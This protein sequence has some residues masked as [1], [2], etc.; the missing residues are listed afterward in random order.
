[1]GSPEE[2]VFIH[3]LQQA[4]PAKAILV[5]VRDKIL[6][7]AG[8]MEPIALAMGYISKFALKEFIC[9]TCFLQTK[10]S[11]KLSRTI[12]PKAE[13]LIPRSLLGNLSSELALGYH[14]CDCSVDRSLFH[15]LAS[16]SI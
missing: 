11:K 12:P 15:G 8:K 3:H 16:I 2:A 10:C 7:F 13:G 9:E 5:F 4:I 1:M 14:T 6:A